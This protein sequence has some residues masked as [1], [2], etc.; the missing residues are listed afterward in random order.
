[1]HFN[2]NEYT[3]LKMANYA[4]SVNVTTKLIIATIKMI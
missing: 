2:I 4:N 1:M 3:L